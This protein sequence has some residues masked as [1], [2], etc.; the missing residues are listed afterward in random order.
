MRWVAATSGSSRRGVRVAVPAA[1][2]VANGFSDG[3]DLFGLEGNE[4]FNPASPTLKDGTAITGDMLTYHNSAVWW[5]LNASA[6]TG[7]YAQ[8]NPTV[9]FAESDVYH[10]CR[11]G[12]R[13]MDS[14]MEVFRLTGDLR[15][16]DRLADDIAGLPWT[17][18]WVGTYWTTYFTDY[19]PAD[20]WSPYSKLL[21]DGA[22][23]GETHVSR[24]TDCS[25]L[26]TG[27]IHSLLAQFAWAL[28]LNRSK[29]SPGG[30]NYNTLANTYGQIMNDFVR[31]WSYDGTGSGDWTSNYMGD[32][33]KTLEGYRRRRT[34]GSWPVFTVNGSHTAQDGILQTYYLGLLAN[35]GL[36]PHLT[37]GNA[38]IAMAQEMAGR[39]I[40]YGHAACTADGQDGW[41]P[42]GSGWLT[43]TN[44]A[45]SIVESSQQTVY[46]GH[47]AGNWLMMW[48]SGAFR[49]Q[50]PLADM[51]KMARVFAAAT[52]PL[53]GTMVANFGLN[54]TGHSLTTASGV[55]ITGVNH[56]VNGYGKMLVFAD[57]G[58]TTLDDAATYVMANV[59]SGG[60]ATP[61][62]GLLAA[63]QFSKLALSSAG[64]I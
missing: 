47:T 14:M 59:V 26:N 43:H 12:Q 40:T 15:L 38:A 9:A 31:A 28:H 55:N 60:Y 24:G 7:D 5:A 19:S 42:R 49:T 61:Q 4:S 8:V 44:I 58:D 21:Y 17:T 37:N 13:C 35:T 56:A 20:S 33:Y 32:D 34:P 25:W 54:V 11:Y 16:L 18:P 3:F 39:V 30:K 52:N 23:G 48:M 6:T 22:G 53:D 1:A 57:P 64:D 45:A 50:L 2:A 62:A 51:R 41:L 29:T 27:K 10:S 36:W 46:G 63:S